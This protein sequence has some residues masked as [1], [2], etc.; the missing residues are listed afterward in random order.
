MQGVIDSLMKTRTFCKKNYNMFDDTFEFHENC[1]EMLSNAAS[2][3]LDLLNFYKKIWSVPL[4]DVTKEQAK[5][6]QKQNRDKVNEITRWAFVSVVSSVEFSSKQLISR[7]LEGPLSTLKKEKRLYLSKIFR[8][9]KEYGI[10]NSQTYNEWTAIIGIRNNMVHNNAIAEYTADYHV[11]D[12]HV[13]FVEGQM[14]QGN[15]LFFSKMIYFVAT[16]IK[17]W[18]HAFINTHRLTT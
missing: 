11:F 1:F 9:S 3:A 2:L 6:L 10:L 16:N 13:S 12:V 8:V 7:I 4:I 18:I 14:I 5:M 17:D 15:L